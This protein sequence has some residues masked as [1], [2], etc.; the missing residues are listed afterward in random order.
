MSATKT[1]VLEEIK[2]QG[3]DDESYQL[4]VDSLQEFPE[5]LDNDNLQK[6]D[7]ILAEMQSADEIATQ[8]HGEIA[9]S[10]EKAADEMY[11]A[12]DKY[13]ED[14]AKI[15]YDNVKLAQDLSK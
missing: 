12:A 11:D 8:V 14:V 6:L 4:I 7:T 13:V 5:E 9:D 15:T 2:T 1:Q 10:M 3:F